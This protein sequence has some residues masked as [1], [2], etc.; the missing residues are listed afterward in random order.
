VN[1]K[2]IL[3]GRTFFDDLNNLVQV[4]KYVKEAVVA[5][6]SDKTN[7]AD[8]FI[9][10]VKLA[11]IIKKIPVEFHKNFRNHCINKFNERWKEFQYDEYLLA[12]FLHPAYKG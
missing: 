9:N 10:L 7:L 11:A 4:L 8:C 12:F 5:L 3:R 1:V 2:R 6:Q